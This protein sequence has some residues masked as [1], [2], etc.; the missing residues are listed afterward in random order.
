MILVDY[1]GIAMGALFARG[2]G[3]EEGLLRHQI[4]NSLRMYNVRY[5]EE[6]GRMIVCADGGSFIS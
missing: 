6:Y 2:G 3:Q 5:R 4:L 1:S